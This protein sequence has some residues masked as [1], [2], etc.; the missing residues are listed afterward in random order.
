MRQVRVSRPAFVNASYCN[1]GDVISISD[2]TALAPFMKLI[3]PTTS[4]PQ[5]H[6]APAV[7]APPK[8]HAVTVS[9]DEIGRKIAIT[10]DGVETKLD[11]AELKL[12]MD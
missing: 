4:L 9:Y 10:I 12:R 7:P 1:A 5:V 11:H 6:T 3:E 8:N 2:A